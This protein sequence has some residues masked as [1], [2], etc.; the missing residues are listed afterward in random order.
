MMW[1]AWQRFVG[2][3]NIA[4]DLAQIDDPTSR[5]QLIFLHMSDE[6][7]SIVQAA[8][9]RPPLGRLDCYDQFLQNVDNHL[10]TDSNAEHRAFMRMEQA[11]GEST[12]T[13]HARLTEKVRLCDYSPSDQKRFVLA[14]LL[15]GMRDQKMAEMARLM[16]LDANAVVKAA[17]LAETGPKKP[18]FTKDEPRRI[19]EPSAGVPVSVQRVVA[20][21]SGENQQ[22][23]GFRRR[24]KPGDN[25]NHAVKKCWRCRRPEHET[26]EFCPAYY[27]RCN[28]CGETGHFAV[29]CQKK[30]RANA[31]FDEDQDDRPRKVKKDQV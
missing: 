21:R 17:N 28:N 20:K 22:A 29:A 12:W 14:Q 23:G 6:L 19:E 3:F 27:R 2:N 7:Q 31:M 16:K 10:R 24:H 1:E 11:E 9:L 18:G 5:C 25:L 8:D 4:A 13:F 15:D 30:K 26:G